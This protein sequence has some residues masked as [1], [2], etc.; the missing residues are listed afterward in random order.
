VQAKIN[1]RNIKELCKGKREIIIRFVD[2]GMH[3]K[4]RKAAMEVIMDGTHNKKNRKRKFKDFKHCQPMIWLE[5][6]S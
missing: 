5:V 1:V 6:F 2:I 3:R 4:I